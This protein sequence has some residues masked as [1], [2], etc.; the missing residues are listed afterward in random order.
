MTT[1]RNQRGFTLMELLITISIM[2]ILSAIVVFSAGD[3]GTTS[4]C[5]ADA[6]MLRNAEASY[7]SSNGRY[8]TQAELVNAQLLRSASTLHDVQVTGLSYTMTELGRCL[9][10]GTAD[11]S[12]V[13]ATTT[14]KR[15]GFTAL[16]ASGDG[17]PVAGA[18]VQ[19]RLTGTTSWTTIGTTGAN[20]MVNAPL[21]DGAYDIQA[22]LFGVVN[23]L[24]GVVVTSGTLVVLPAVEVTIRLTDTSN[25]GI[26]GAAAQLRSAGGSTWSS[27]GV[28][29]SNGDVTVQVLPADY[30][31][32]VTLN[33]VTSTRTAVAVNQSTII[34]F[35]TTTLSVHLTNSVGAGVQG[36]VVTVTP[37]G[38]SAYPSN[39][40]DSTG[41]ARR[42]VLS[43]QYDVRVVFTK[44]GDSSTSE[45]SVASTPVA[46]SPVVVEMQV[47]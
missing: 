33:G 23:Q 4:A 43:G 3:F 27:I 24:E 42:E 36:A 37:T 5:Q 16:I 15:P 38:G 25:S 7:F 11:S 35:Q 2:G 12:V 47:Q 28:T 26:S 21:P 14:S 19:Y 40:T 46:S 45:A 41:W 31:A 18:V 17:S 8:A 13:A 29:A 10:Q 30:D 34:A 20:G 1:A 22:S 39:T 32:S 44:P 6:K 9:N